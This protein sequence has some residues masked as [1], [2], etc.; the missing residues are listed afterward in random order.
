[1]ARSNGI[2]PLLY[3]S[4]TAACA[5]A[6]P[7][8]TLN[9]LADLY[10]INVMRSLA[11]TAELLRLLELLDAHGIRAVPFKG[12]VLAA[13]A[14]G[15]VTLR[16]FYDLDILV[17]KRDLQRARELLLSQGYLTREEATG[18]QDCSPTK[19]HWYLVQGD[20][21]MGLDLHWR[22]TPRYFS[23]PVDGDRLWSR[24]D[25]VSLLG[26][27]VPSL[28]PEDMLLVLCAH[29][30]TG[31][32]ARLL[33]VCDVAQLISARSRMDWRGVL[34]QASRTGSLRRL[35]L[36]L[37]LAGDLLG[38]AIPREA[39]ALMAADTHLPRLAAEVRGRMLS[40]RHAAFGHVE[41]CRTHLRM[42]ERLRD[43][44][45]YCL[46]LLHE[47]VTPNTTDRLFV[48]LPRFLHWLYYLIHPVRLAVT[49]GPSA[50]KHL[51]KRAS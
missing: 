42:M 26:L 12:P 32:W 27:A 48:P 43:R 29:G 41:S 1:M 4:L 35:L 13:S 11:V 20:C 19:K 16:E 38:A 44:M 3:R 5:D 51:L 21:G 36:G 2:T 39:L 9:H 25:R 30:A 45:L 50:L 46:G 34:E 15:D 37:L 49:Y 17:D 23:S 31:C 6:V 14:Y 28:S 22:F 40:A 8:A 24:L 7:A 47:S 10:R 33:L 18:I